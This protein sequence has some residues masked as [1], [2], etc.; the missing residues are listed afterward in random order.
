MENIEDIKDIVIKCYTEILKRFPH[1]NEIKQVINDHKN[2]LNSEFLKEILL[3]S[4]EYNTSKQGHIMWSAFLNETYEA[5][6][7]LKVKP[8][9]EKSSNV[10]VIVEPRKHKLLE[11]TL[12]NIMHMLNGKWS[13][14][15]FHGPSNEKFVRNI[16]AKWNSLKTVKFINTN[17]H[18]ILPLPQ[19]NE[20]DN[21]LKSLKFWNCLKGFDYALC[22]Q[23]DTLM[24]DSNINEFIN[25]NYD[26][27]G[28]PWKYDDVNGGHLEVGCGGF[29]LRKVSKMIE[30][31]KTHET[32]SNEPEDIFFSKHITNKP[33][34]T[35]AKYFCTE[36][37]LCEE[38]LAIHRPWLYED[39]IYCLQKLKD[40]LNIV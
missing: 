11:Y 25:M 35:I 9:P 33:S 6:V 30:I 14:V 24:L 23:T 27:I 37:I 31:I 22:I 7:K 1:E 15:I 10:V 28:A 8:I 21:F 16:V 12:T 20:Y 38:S 32:S 29:S 40:Y 13:L 26:Y 3:Q 4:N 5:V 18:N 39:N 34:L 36:H 2:E 19:Q 17:K